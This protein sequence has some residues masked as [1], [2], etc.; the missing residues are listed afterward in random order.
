MAQ[1]YQYFPDPQ[2]AIAWY[3]SAIRHDVTFTPAYAGLSELYNKAGD[4]HAGEQTAWAG[5]DLGAA[6]GS[7]AEEVVIGQALYANLGWAA[8]GQGK[9]ALAESAFL[10]AITLEEQ[11]LKEEQ[12]LREQGY[13]KPL[14]HY[15]LAHLYEQKGEAAEAVNQYRK[16]ARCLQADNLADAEWLAVIRSKLQESTK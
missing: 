11:V 16:A 12:T 13:C 15:Y 2:E 1:V 14:P 8:Y 5:L 4:F 3:Q 9:F 7:Q 10:Q 6:G